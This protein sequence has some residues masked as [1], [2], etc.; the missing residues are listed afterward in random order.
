MVAPPKLTP[1]AAVE[2]APRGA[3]LALANPG[4]LKPAIPFE[5]AKAQLPLPAQGKRVLAFGERIQ[6]GGG[7]SKGIVV[8][9]R[10]GAQIVSPTDGWIVYAG[11]F[12]AYGQ[13]LIINAGAGYHIVLAGLS[14]I[15][16]QI[17][18]FVLAAEPVGTMPPSLRRSASVGASSAPVLYVEFRKDGRPIDPEP[19]WMTGQ[20][21]V[22]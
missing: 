17:G 9:T 13:L 12:R 3:S 19:W 6:T 7:R 1:P 14:Q 20:Q 15:D 5:Q 21:K 4:R 22:Q 11:P 16:V 2:L 10:H 18:Q 8:E